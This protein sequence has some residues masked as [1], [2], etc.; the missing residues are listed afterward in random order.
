MGRGSS[1]SRIDGHRY[2]GYG[3]R[4]ELRSVPLPVL[5]G[6]SASSAALESL[7]LDTALAAVRVVAIAIALSEPVRVRVLDVLRR[8]RE[9]VCQCDLVALFAM[10]RSLLSDHMRKLVY[11]G[12]VR[13]E[14][15][16]K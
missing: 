14:Q 2:H 8:G 6:P 5:P 1:E 10:K 4:S 7:S 11:A 13:I 12:V 3:R 16:H 15:R 9:P